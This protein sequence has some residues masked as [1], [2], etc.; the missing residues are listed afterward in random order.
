MFKHVS[1]YEFQ[2]T[3]QYIP[4]IMYRGKERG[5]MTLYYCIVAVPYFVSVFVLVIRCVAGRSCDC[6]IACGSGD[7]GSDCFGKKDAGG[8]NRGSGCVGCGGSSGDSVYDRGG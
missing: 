8:G 5:K 6:G 3:S 7:D 4:E 1:A 2:I